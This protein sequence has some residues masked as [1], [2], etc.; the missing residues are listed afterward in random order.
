MS[1]RCVDIDEGR[2]GLPEESSTDG[3]WRMSRRCV[4]VDEGR[5]G[6]SE[7]TWIVND[8]VDSRYA[9][10]RAE[11]RKEGAAVV[12]RFLADDEQ[13][14]LSTPTGRPHFGST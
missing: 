11:E 12:R 7:K 8:V 1:C 2:E 3:R 10:G 4:D 14:A 6:L 9:A 13:K 5:E